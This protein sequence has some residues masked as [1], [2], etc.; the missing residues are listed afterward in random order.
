MD[1]RV[2]VEFLTPG[3][4]YAEES[5]FCTEMLRIARDF[6]QGFRTGAKQEIVDNLLVLQDQGS[7]MP[8]KREDHMHVGRREQF[9]ATCCEPAVARSCLT[10]WAV[11][12][13]TRVVGD[14]AMSAAGA[15][16]EVAAERGGA[17]P[18]DGQ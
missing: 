10:L 2:N 17:T 5:D 7:Q 3:V 15:F 13:S 9:L 1:M 14:G 8:G 6:E 4:Q 18:H 16:I 12:V 11:P